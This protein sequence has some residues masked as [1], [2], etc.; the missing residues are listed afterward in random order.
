MYDGA[1][2]WDQMTFGSVVQCFTGITSNIILSP[3]MGNPA[4][5]KFGKLW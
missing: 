3:I 4:R 2:T 5:G 1:R